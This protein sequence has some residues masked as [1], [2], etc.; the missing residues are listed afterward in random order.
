MDS[1]SASM[2]EP[3]KGRELFSGASTRLSVYSVPDMEKL[4]SMSKSADVIHCIDFR[5]DG[6]LFAV[7]NSAGNIQVFDSATKK[8]IRN[9]KGH[10]GAVRK[11][12]F[13]P[14]KINLF[15]ISDDR[16][17]KVWDIPTETE[18][19][20]VEAHDDYIRACAISSNGKYFITGAY[21][22]KIKVWN[23]EDYSLVMTIDN[24]TP[25]EDLLISM[26]GSMIISTG[27]NIIKFWDISIGGHLVHS[28]SPH[29]KTITSIAYNSD[30]SHIITGGLDRISKVIDLS[31]YRVV[32]GFKFD[33]PVM[34]VA[35]NKHDSALSFGLANGECI[36]KTRKITI[37]SIAAVNSDEIKFDFIAPRKQMKFTKYEKAFKSFKFRDAL[38]ECLAIGNPQIVVS[39]FTE[40]M[41]YNALNIAIAGR[42]EMSLLPV[43]KFISKSI[44]NPEFCHI[45]LEVFSEIL[46]TYGSKIGQSPEID[47]CLS[48]ILSKMERE[49]KIAKQMSQVSGQLEMICSSSSRSEF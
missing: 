33:S 11:I 43:L 6:K 37:D 28:M 18:I 31:S 48:I 29:Q 46:T 44:Q 47:E 9:L 40:L 17:F 19:K 42:D 39:C 25:V 26:N 4:K 36:M 23:V 35:C 2:F 13:S 32:Q 14:N 38:D 5:S 41:V 10:K 12:N 30:F 15:S 24:G 1:I 16:T 34:C 27:S 22:H 3:T 7:G 8:L 49:I 21:D 20:T 45:S